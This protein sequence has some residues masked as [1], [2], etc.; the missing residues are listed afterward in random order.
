M[1]VVDIFLK[2][3]NAFRTVNIIGEITQILNASNVIYPI[4]I[5]FSLLHITIQR[6]WRF[7]LYLL[8]NLDDYKL[9]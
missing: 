4:F 6:L 2:S 5:Y 9:V 3:R 7:K 1:Y 8:R